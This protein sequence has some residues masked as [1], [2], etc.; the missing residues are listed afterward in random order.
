MKQAVFNKETLENQG[1]TQENIAGKQRKKR[2]NEMV[3]FGE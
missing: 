1:M 2:H 3:V